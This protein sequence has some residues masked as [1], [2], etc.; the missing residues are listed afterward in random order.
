MMCKTTGG[1]PVSTWVLK[2]CSAYRGPV[3]SQIH[4]ETKLNC[5][6]RTF[7]SRGLI[8]ASPDPVFSWAG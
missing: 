5:E 7:R 6:R 2:Q 8:P 4:L 1:D 3:T